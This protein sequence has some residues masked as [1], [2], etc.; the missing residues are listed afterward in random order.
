[1][2]FKAGPAKAVLIAPH[3]RQGALDCGCVLTETRGHVHTRLCN[4]CASVLFTSDGKALQT[5]DV[6]SEAKK[7]NSDLL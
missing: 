6:V 4:A 5:G 3:E 1:V 2:R 7:D